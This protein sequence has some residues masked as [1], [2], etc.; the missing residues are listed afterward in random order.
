[1]KSNVMSLSIG[2]VGSQLQYKI[3]LQKD[4]VPTGYSYT[5][6]YLSVQEY[7]I[8]TF[9]PT[10]QEVSNPF[11]F[12]IQ[13]AETSSVHNV[14]GTAT[15]P[16]CAELE[17][18]SWL[19]DNETSLQFGTLPIDLP[20]DSF[21]FSVL[22]R[23]WRFAAFGNF[24]VLRLLIDTNVPLK[25]QNF[26]VDSR[27][28]LKE[29]I[30]YP[31][32]NSTW[33]F[34]FLNVVMIDGIMAP[35]LYTR[36]LPISVNPLNATIEFAFPYFQNRLIYDPDFSVL[37]GTGNNSV[38]EFNY[39]SLDSIG[40]SSILGLNV[41]MSVLIGA[42]V[43]LAAVIVIFITAIGIIFRVRKRRATMRQLRENIERS[44][45][46]HTLSNSTNS[47]SV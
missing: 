38:P 10:C 20:K 46:S 3:A 18:D 45:S 21:K 5:V 42:V 47:G 15:L 14:N 25:S 30:V 4:G 24:L 31:V 35:V 11:D 16:N 1:M 29:V 8:S 33:T 13:T 44:Q 12:R 40:V 9:S 22:M 19:F 26:T 43:A 39:D 41:S 2:T 7:S 23:N 6:T 17:V 27:G 28:N 34:R 36:L 32:D 37:L